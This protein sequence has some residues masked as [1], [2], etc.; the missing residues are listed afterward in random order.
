MGC[1]TSKLVAKLVLP[2]E[3]RVGDHI[4]IR[5]KCNSINAIYLNEERNECIYLDVKTGFV[6]ETSLSTLCRDRNKLYKY[7]YSTKCIM[8]PQE[9]VS[10]LKYFAARGKFNDYCC[11]CQFS[12]SYDFAYNCKVNKYTNCEINH[13]LSTSLRLCANDQKESSRSL[14]NDNNAN[15]II[16]GGEGKNETNKTQTHFI[17]S[18]NKTK[19]LGIQINRVYESQ[20]VLLK[21][22]NAMD[23]EIKNIRKRFFVDTNT[24]TNTPKKDTITNGGSSMQTSMTLTP[25]KSESGVQRSGG[26]GKSLEMIV[27]PDFSNDS[28]MSI[29]P[30]EFEMK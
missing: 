11:L 4:L 21:K 26:F 2:H 16:I 12:S 27:V 14:I 10:N 8:S 19:E 6:T 1:C 23:E 3:L 5:N 29:S 18:D 24:E 13:S 20:N 7:D 22:L 9:T 30:H 25:I 28:A 17:S 15:D